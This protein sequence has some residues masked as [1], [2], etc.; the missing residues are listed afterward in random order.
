M[1]AWLNSAINL[2]VI[3][4][5]CLALSLCSNSAYANPSEKTIENIVL[6]DLNNATTQANNAYPSP[7]QPHVGSGLVTSN[8]L[9]H[10]P[11]LNAVF[12][13]VPFGYAPAMDRMNGDTFEY[14]SF[15]SD[16]LTNPVQSSHPHLVM[17]GST[18]FNRLG[19]R[20]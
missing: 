17:N 3:V 10:K 8:Q 2:V 5:G 13:C 7:V 14:A 18:S 6:I 19:V 15:L 4:G 1:T 16:L 9:A 11:R 20:P 12:C